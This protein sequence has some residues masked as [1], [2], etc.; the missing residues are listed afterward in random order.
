ME[1][2]IQF[3]SADGIELRGV[4]T[5]PP[6]PTERAIILAHG[7]T[8]EKNED[9]IFTNLAN[10]LAEHRF[11]VFRFDFRGHG[12]SGGKSVNVTLTGE[13]Q[14]LD[15]AV[16]LVRAKGYTTLGLVGASFGG[17]VSVL[18]TARHKN[19][20]TKLCLWNPVLNYDHCFL[21]PT[22]PWLV[23]RKGHMKTDIREKG[24]TTLG[25]HGFIVGK[26][27]FEEMAQFSPHKEIANLSLP[28]FIIHGDKDTKVP[29]EDSMSAAQQ[30]SNIS[31]L[32][33]RGAEHGFHDADDHAEE[34][35]RATLEFFQKERP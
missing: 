8:V 20:F 4:W 33:I 11:A 30:S 2:K 22:L 16:T 13:Q 12:E 5:V 23:E 26:A 7:I 17:G 9:G 6:K 24:W 25:S 28:V 29:Y 3:Q 19:T 10:Y 15:A 14:D 1:E 27:L 31:L 21:N 18:Y 34:A 35:N 32:T